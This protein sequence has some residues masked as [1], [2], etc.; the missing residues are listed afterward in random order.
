MIDKKDNVNRR[1]SPKNIK[2]VNGGLAYE[3]KKADLTLNAAEFD[4]DTGTDLDK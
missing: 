4:I 3:V 1:K 2:M